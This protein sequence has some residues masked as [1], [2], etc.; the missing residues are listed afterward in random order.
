MCLVKIID[1]FENSLD[2]FRLIPW[3]TPWQA[4]LAKRFLLG[5][6]V[7]ALLAILHFLVSLVE[8]T[9]LCLLLSLTILKDLLEELKSVSC[10][11]MYLGGGSS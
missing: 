7:F 10:L 6:L 9:A 3:C 5:L 11:L 4:T 2:N 1:N 8:T